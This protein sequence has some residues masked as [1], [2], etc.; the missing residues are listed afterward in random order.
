MAE[1]Q[2]TRIAYGEAL[3]KLGAVNDKVLVC[4]ADLAHATMTA[5][6][7]N[8][9]PDR[10]YNF[11]IAEA[12]MMAASAAMSHCGYTVFASTFAI[13]GAG[14]AFEQ[15]RNAICYTNAN[16][17]LGLSHA[18]PS[19]GE[20]G[21]SHQAVEDISLMRTLPRM[22]VLVP[23]DAV[24]MEKAVF[25]AAEIDGPVYIRTGRL[26]TDICTTKDTP[27][28]VGKATTLRE[29]TDIAIIAC[30]IMVPQAL[31]AAE[32]LKAQGV[33]A[34][35]INMHT[36]KPL[37]ADA[38]LAAA[39]ECGAIVTAEEHSIIGGLGSAVAEVLAD[40]SRVPFERVGIM[41][42]FGQSGKPPVLFEAY[43]LTSKAIVEACQRV[44][45]RKS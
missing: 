29:G 1:K 23:C 4:D 26:P 21:G 44:L 34:K 11:G 15:V 37:D 19:C 35:V 24:E 39:K 30:G 6:F 32:D 10:F 12:N 14:R 22:T 18:G 43:G 42:R 8:E 5:N 2:S 36:I 16:V 40:N 3:K 31:Q 9:Y 33:N 17:K 41:D 13:F 28:T 27:F 25:A 7:A 38:V 20:D 45:A